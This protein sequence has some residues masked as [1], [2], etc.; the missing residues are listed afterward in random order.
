MPLLIGETFLHPD[1]APDLQPLQTLVL[2][3]DFSPLVLYTLGHKNN[4]KYKYNCKYKINT[5]EFRLQCSVS[6]PSVLYNSRPVSA[7]S[8]Y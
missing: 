2:V 3:F 4:N 6:L 1:E 5:R 7:R 8:E